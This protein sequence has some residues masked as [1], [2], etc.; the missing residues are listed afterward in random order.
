VAK[1]NTLIEGDLYRHGTNDIL[2][3][4][5]TWEDGYEQLLEIH[6]SECGNHASSHMWVGKAFWHGF[7]YPT[8]VQDAIELV[9][10]CKA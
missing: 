1:R 6:A 9:K 7:Y 10:R 3:R 2:M 8:A 5:I 4:C